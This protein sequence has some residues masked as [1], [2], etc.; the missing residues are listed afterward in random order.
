MS[1]KVPGL[2]SVKAASE[3]LK[4]HGFHLKKRYGQN[5][6][7]DS[8]VTEKIINAAG[9]G[10]DDFIIEIGPGIGTLTQYLAYY[11]AEV[12]AVEIDRSLIPVLEDTLSDY[13]NVT[14]LC[15]DIMKTDLAS[16]IAEKGQGRH[17][18]IVA[19]LPYYITTPILMSLF[20]QD[21]AFES[22][23]VMMQ[24]EVGLRVCAEPGKP[25]YGALSLAVHYY[26]E[27]ETAANVP[28][29]CFMPRPDVSSIVLKLTRRTE[30]PE[31]KDEKLLFE[32]IRA[33]F[34]KRRKTLYNCLRSSGIRPF[35][36][37]QWKER[38]EE[39]GLDPQVRGEMLELSDFI[40]LTDSVA[41]GQK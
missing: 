15:Q 9:V 11:A 23:T 21:L 3:V 39:A 33:S 26:A 37:E 8:H 31:V 29:N 38:I 13:D 35:S 24:K 14:I 7:I 27:A 34:A 17:V 12:F 32:I 40:R 16:V 28:Q 19:N 41:E 1:R 10:G 20:E 25:E 22:A 36:D 18:K 30:K 6:L 5:F 4:R 2:A